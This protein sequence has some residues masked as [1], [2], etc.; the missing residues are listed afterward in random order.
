MSFWDKFGAGSRD[1]IGKYAW[2]IVI[3]VLKETAEV[4][5]AEFAAGLEQYRK[6]RKTPDGWTEEEY[7]TYAVGRLKLIES[8]KIGPWYV[9]EALDFATRQLIGYLEG[10]IEHLDDPVPVPPDEDDDEPVPAPAPQPQ[11][12]P[13]PIPDPFVPPTAPEPAP[14][15][16]PAPLPADLIYWPKT[17]G[18]YEFPPMEK[19]NKGDRIYK[20]A[21]CRFAVPLHGE[22]Q[23]LYREAIKG[24][25]L[26]MI[27]GEN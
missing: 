16:A 18:P 3:A 23:P 26:A 5:L 4:A 12:I 13:T 25:T 10:K 6:E 17:Y 9:D 2:A 14:A 27:I 7:L 8:R 15:P 22:S 20:N 1:Q 11:P 19:Y 24:A 21:T